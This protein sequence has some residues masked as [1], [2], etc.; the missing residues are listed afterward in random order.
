MRII[1]LSTFRR[2]YNPTRGL[3]SLRRGSFQ[4]Q[5]SARRINQRWLNQLWRLALA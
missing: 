2:C 5:E 4:L 3:Q 1:A